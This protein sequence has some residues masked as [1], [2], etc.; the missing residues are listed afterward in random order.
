MA[1][2]PHI[3][4]FWRDKGGA[5]F[6]CS[7]VLIAPRFVITVAHAFTD[8]AIG[9][10]SYVGLLPGKHGVIPARL[11]ARHDTWDA[12]LFKLEEPMEVARLVL[13]DEIGGYKGS[14]AVLYAIDPDTYNLTM[15]ADYSV[16]NYADQDREYVLD[17][18]T[19]LGNSGGLLTVDGK[20]IGLL[21]RRVQGDPIARAIALAKLRP[22][23]AL[24][25]DIPA[26]PG[27]TAAFGESGEYDVLE[28][29]LG[30][31]VLSLLANEG[32]AELR[33][34]GGFPNNWNLLAT[35]SLERRFRALVVDLTQATEQ[36]LGGWKMEGKAIPK[37]FANDCRLLLG[38]LIKQA[39]DQSKPPEEL[40]EFDPTVPDR[41]FVPCQ[42]AGTA[43][44]VFSYLKRYPLR[45]ERYK[46]DESDVDGGSIITLSH[47]AQG[48]GTDAEQD[49]Y[50]AAW[51][52]F[53]RTQPPM[54]L[55]PGNIND[56]KVDINIGIEDF[57][58]EPAFLVARG[59]REWLHS[60]GLTKASDNLELGLVIH[61]AGSE[62]A[63]LAIPEQRLNGYL[64]RYIKLLESH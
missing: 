34:V 45:I 12:A 43:A 55:T 47:L 42:R 29:L 52:A 51:L 64:C 32:T 26:N 58:R 22:W 35:L 21:N 54:R 59:P 44:A 18:Q 33:R 53:K 10:P 48:V 62:Y 14:H 23:I 4:S 8:L 2:K 30:Q 16:S 19:A 57:G 50:Q 25:I 13:P 39:I 9:D 63:F 40:A 1:A 31:Q 60:S 27:A 17:K 38:E 15:L 7:G 36:C 20:A 24:A 28:S 11:H 56:L 41:V 46:A 49:V 6:L 61:D 5:E 37:K 3:V